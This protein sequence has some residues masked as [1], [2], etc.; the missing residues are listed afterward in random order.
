MYIRMEV[1][2]TNSEKREKEKKRPKNSNKCSNAK[3]KP[4]QDHMGEK[5]LGPLRQGQRLNTTGKRAQL[6]SGDTKSSPC[7]NASSSSP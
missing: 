3:Q 2:V 4:K 6:N 1:V 5:N 7:M